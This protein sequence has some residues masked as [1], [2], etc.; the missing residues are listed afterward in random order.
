MSVQDIHRASRGQA[1]TGKWATLATGKRVLVV[2]H[3]EVYGKRLQDL[4]PL[5]EADLR[6]EVTFTVAPH[7]FNAGAT[8]FLRA[9][10]ATVVS[11]D[12]AV[13]TEYDLALAAGSAGIQQLR[14][15]LVRVSHGAGHMKLARAEDV[16]HGETRAPGGITGKGYLTWEGEVVPAAVALAHRDDLA[17]LE[18]WCPEALSIATVTGDP[19]YDRILRS[20]PLRDDYRAALGLLPGQKLVLVSSTWGKTSSFNR[21]GALLPRLLAELPQDA[22][23]VAV[24]VHPN[25]WA[26]YGAWQVRA[27][28]AGCRDAGYTVLSP[29]ADWRPPLIAADW[30]IGDYGSVTL[31]GTM[32]GAPILMTHFPHRDA[33]PASPGLELAL[34]AP[35]LSA[36]HPL[37]EQ[38]AYAKDEYVA[39]DYARIAARLSSEPGLSSRNFRRLL[40]RVL[41]L[42]QPAFPPGTPP[43]P[44]PLPL[45][46]LRA[47]S[48]SARGGAS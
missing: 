39:E 17:A 31:Y 41:G 27:W 6:F 47:A 12:E 10:G 48:G 20:L 9:L 34:T 44:M 29:E 2:V 3:T 11:W 35:T 43:L 13:R 18:R 38:L 40:Y 15:P 24:L 30:I 45:E 42:G 36:S 8:D 4:L 22:F 32:T 23:R 7:P 28:L 19:C 21:I 14:A 16:P 25:V 37:T 5:L 46:T 1:T 33:N 26:R